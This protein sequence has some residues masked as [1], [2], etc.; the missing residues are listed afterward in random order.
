[1]FKKTSHKILPPAPGIGL[2]AAHVEE[3]LA[4]RPDVA[5]LE[6][7][8]ENYMTDA[9]ALALLQRV[10][11]QY[12]LSLHG[13]GL[14][15]GTA[16]P[17]NLRHLGRLKSLVE[18][19][20]PVLV[21]EH[22]AWSMTG[23]VHLNELLP[24]PYTEEALDTV[25]TH[26]HQVQ[27]ALGRTILIENPSSYLRFRQSTMSEAA[28]LTE[29]VRRT[30]CGLLLDINNLYVSAHN[31]GVNARDYFATVPPAAIG[32]FHLAGHARNVVGG[33][34]VLIDDHGSSVSEEVWSL[35]RDAIRCFGHRPAL[36]EWDTDLPPLE[37]LLGE[38][39]RAETQSTSLDP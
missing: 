1:M 17:L 7:H 2:R 14:S 38:A 25:T 36:I 5:W 27:A 34:I 4:H 20:E 18:R 26:V 31:V 16:G 13:V 15:L 24:L 39:A 35:Y 37:V 8:P 30:D 32:E 28:F 9:A 33:A 10:R 19:L 22:L 11:E 6:V 21:S 12:P 23:K 3:V 29:L